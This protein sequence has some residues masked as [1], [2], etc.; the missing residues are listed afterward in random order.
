[1]ANIKQQK[2]RIRTAE[3][4][5]VENLRYKSTT[6]TLFRRL[7]A[8]VNASDTEAAQSTHKELTRLLDRASTKNVMHANTAA[9]KKARASR[10]LIAE[11]VKETKATRRPKK[12]AAPR[13]AKVA[14]TKTAKATDA[15]AAA[16]AEAT[17]AD[18]EAVA[19]TEDASAAEVA[20]KP[21]AKKP[22]AKKPAAKK[23]AAKKDA[24][25]AADE[26]AAADEA[27]ADDK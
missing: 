12:K 1:M 8:A 23:P 9:R 25:P 7:E 21:A 20:K 13:T 24:E 19:T 16:S 6:K 22:A 5:R 17:A 14:T 3:R 11:P 10:M 4:Q 26:A 2:K 15:K 18:T 27:P